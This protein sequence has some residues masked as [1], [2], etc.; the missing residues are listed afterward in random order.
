M[1]SRACSPRAT[2]SSRSRGREGAPRGDGAAAASAALASARADALP[3]TDDTLDSQAG[4]ARA[5]ADLREALTRDPGNAEARVL[6]AELLRRAERLDDADALLGGLAPAAAARGAALVEATARAAEARGLASGPSS[7]PR[8]RSGE[9]PLRRGRPR[10]R[11]RRSP[12]RHRGE[13]ERIRAVA[14]C[15]DGAARLGEHLRRRGDAAAPSRR[16]RRLVAARPWAIEP[17]LTQAGALVAARRRRAGGR[18]AR[19]PAGARPQEPR[20]SRRSSPTCASWPA[21]R[22]GA[23]A[24]RAGAAPRRSRPRAAPRP[25]ARGRARGARRSRRGRPRRDPRVR[26]RRV[27]AGRPPRRWC[28]TRPRSRST[29]AAP[30]PSGRT[31]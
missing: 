14:A 2:Q 9:R 12:P 28:S 29:R 7:S 26:A 20:A 4:R 6:L 17:A 23:R 16:S 5:E 30:P 11:A 27:R 3:L 15:R 8:A 25:R 10:L 18:D 19:R 13:D 22:G 21:T 1:P 31:R 24:A